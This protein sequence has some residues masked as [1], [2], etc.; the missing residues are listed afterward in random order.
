MR[1]FASLNGVFT[2]DG[3]QPEYALAQLAGGR[4]SARAVTTV[5]SR[6]RAA[7]VANGLLDQA[8]LIRVATASVGV[9]GSQPPLVV[10]VTQQSVSYTH[11]TLPTSDLV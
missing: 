9:G 2:L 5:V 8:E 10:V 4:R 3:D 11:L 1:S 7:L 6:V